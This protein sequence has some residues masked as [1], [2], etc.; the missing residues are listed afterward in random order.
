MYY[1]ER[2]FLEFWSGRVSVA[3][4]AWS[5][6]V[7]AVAKIFLILYSL[8]GH[9]KRILSLVLIAG[10]VALVVRVGP[11]KSWVR[12]VL[13]LVS[14]LLST[15]YTVL[16]L[17]GEPLYRLIQNE[18]ETIGDKEP[19]ESAMDQAQV[20]YYTKRYYESENEKLDV[21][22]VSSGVIDV[23]IDDPDALNEV[24]EGMR[25]KIFFDESIEYS[26]QTHSRA[27]YLATAKVEAVS[28]PDRAMQLVVVDWSNKHPVQRLKLM[29]GRVEE[30]DAYVRVEIRD[31]VRH[32]ELDELE[33]L[34]QNVQTVSQ[35]K[36][37]T[38]T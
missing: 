12:V 35:N 37:E 20:N 7:N 21:I 13:F 6:V 30:L 8:F 10:T 36:R 3:S 34:Y 18:N 5:H 29:W 16:R 33:S 31:E 23:D 22:K 4:A 26:G 17:I 11:D 2:M 38:I 15:D 25:F 32:S 9:R 14:L 24:T 28:I 27:R 1:L 19:L